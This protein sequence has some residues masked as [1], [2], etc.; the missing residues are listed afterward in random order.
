MKLLHVVLVVALT[1]A[2]TLVM[3]HFTVSSVVQG[4]TS[5]A[6]K[7]PA[8]ERVMRTGTLRCGYLFYPKFIERDP[9]TNA[10]SGMWY[11]LMNEIGKQL[12]LKIEWTEE[13]GAANAFDGLKSGRYDAVCVPFNQTPGRARVTE[14]TAP[15][16]FAPTY[17]YVRADDTRFDNAY[18]KINDPS[19]RFAYME[20]EFSQYLKAEKFPKAQTVSLPNLTDVSQ[21]YMQ[22]AMGK[23]DVLTTEPSTIEPFLLN[24]PGKLKRVVGAPLRLQASGISVGVGEEALKALL[25]TTSGRCM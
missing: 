1:I 21:V 2:T 19:V 12:S 20:G 18:E 3:Q 9:N 6:A 25:D 13:V 10:F 8:Y 7:E 16:I 11:D 14:F 22:I 17:A 15:I 23:A 5:V 24:N 4:E